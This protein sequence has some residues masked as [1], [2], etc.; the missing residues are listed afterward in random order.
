MKIK[1][2]WKKCYYNASEFQG[3]KNNRDESWWSTFTDGWNR[4]ITRCPRDGPTTS[5]AR[6]RVDQRR[7]CTRLRDTTCLAKFDR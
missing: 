5:P 4:S 1:L 3:M 6:G 7:A 2:E